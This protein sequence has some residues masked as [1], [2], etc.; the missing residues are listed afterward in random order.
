ME[1]RKSR[2]ELWLEEEERKAQPRPQPKRTRKWTHKDK[3]DR[4][5]KGFWA[6]TEKV[7]ECLEWTGK[8]QGYRHSVPYAKWDGKQMN[9]RRIVY[10]LALGD[11]ADDLFVVTTCR[12]RRCVRQSHLLRVTEQEYDAYRWDRS[13]MPADR[14]L[15][16]EK[17]GTSKLSEDDVRLIRKL[18]AQG[19]VTLAELGHRFSVDSTTIRDVVSRRRWTH[20]Q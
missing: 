11:V 13:A 12:N 3:A 8:Y 16:G 18:Y 4:F 6:K 14:I 20:V 9:L 10:K 5:W 1:E 7:G 17:V 19:G 15:V 2:Y